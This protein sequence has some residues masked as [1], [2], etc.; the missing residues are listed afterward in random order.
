L[1]AGVAHST[2][3]LGLDRSGTTSSMPTAPVTSAGAK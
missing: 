1:T 2:Q 3:I